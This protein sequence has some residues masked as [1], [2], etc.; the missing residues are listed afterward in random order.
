MGKPQYKVGEQMFTLP[1][2]G[3]NATYEHQGNTPALS[4]GEALY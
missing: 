3:S 2:M 4:K 1:T